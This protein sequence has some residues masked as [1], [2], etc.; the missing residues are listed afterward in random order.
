MIARSFPPGSRVRDKRQPDIAGT[1][2]P[3][4]NDMWP[5]LRVVAWDGS[6]TPGQ[7]I[8]SRLIAADEKNKRDA[9]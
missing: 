1:V 6:N 4:P 5:A 9:A 3:S 7:I 2:R 8:V